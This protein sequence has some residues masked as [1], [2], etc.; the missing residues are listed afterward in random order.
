MPQTLAGGSG[1]RS[2]L[3]QQ[4]ED[5]LS[6]F[7][8]GAVPIGDPPRIHVHVIPH[9]GK[10]AGVAGDLE[11]GNRGKTDG[12]APAGGEGNQVHP[13]RRQPGKRNRIIAGRVHVGEAGAVDSF[14]VIQNFVERRGACLGDG[15][16]GFLEDVA[17]AAFFVAGRRIVVEAPAKTGQVA[18]V[19]GHQ[20]Q[21]AL[22]RGAGARAFD[23]Q[24]LRPEVLRCFSEHHRGAKTGQEIRAE[25]ESGVG[26]DAGEGVRTSAV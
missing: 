13:A 19:V 6:G 25:T 3:Q 18:L 4:I 7:L 15:A 8:D 24:M 11:H 1:A 16:K 21:Q 26:R 17:Q 2:Y 12:A 14:G 9:P 10:R 20:F 5:L 22:S 23:Q